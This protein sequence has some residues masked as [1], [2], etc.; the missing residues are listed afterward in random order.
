MGRKALH[1]VREELRPA[2]DGKMAVESRHILM[3]GGV[4]E[5]ESRGDLFLAVSFLETRERLT[6]TWR[7]LPDTRLGS[8][9]ERTTDQT[10]ELTMEEFD[11]TQLARGEVT[12]TG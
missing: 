4:A 5:P 3:D 8:A 11:E 7:E 2:L 9:H 10:A 12:I 6:K 1:H